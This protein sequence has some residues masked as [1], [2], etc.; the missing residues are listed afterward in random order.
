VS[1]RDSSP[2]TASA[3][4]PRFPS[5]R[6]GWTWTLVKCAV[7]MITAA[8]VATVAL[9]A[10]LRSLLGW[11]PG[12]LPNSWAEWLFTWMLK[13]VWFV[14]PIL[15]LLIGALISVGIVVV[16]AKRGRLTRI[17]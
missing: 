4:A 7:A 13:H 16:D 3:P 8:L 2:E 12:W 10:F 14:G 15:G 9:V 11:L 5:R 6:R 1:D 17:R